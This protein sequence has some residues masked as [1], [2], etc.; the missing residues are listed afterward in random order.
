M[1]IKVLVADDSQIMCTA[2]RRTLEQEPCIRV[3][4]EAPS[5]A[6]AIQMIADLRPDVLLL[7]LHTVAKR[8]LK[9]ESVKLQLGCVFTV[10][11]SFSNDTDDRE[12]A[13]RYGTSSLLNKME[14]F[15]EMIPA[16]KRCVPDLMD[17]KTVLRLRRPV[18][19]QISANEL[20]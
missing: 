11:M 15:T 10:A 9:P 19:R 1:S 6:R 2:I 4:G 13:K 14:L 8:D 12:L 17:S 5:Y 20:I 7:D 3:V 18:Q 16:I